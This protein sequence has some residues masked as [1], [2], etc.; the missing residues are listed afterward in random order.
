VYNSGNFQFKAKQAYDKAQETIE[1]EKS[2]YNAL[3]KSEWRDIYGT[4]FPA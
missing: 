4:N 1:D 2:G 3:A